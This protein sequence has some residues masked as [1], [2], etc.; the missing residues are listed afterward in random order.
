MKELTDQELEKVIAGCKD[1]NAESYSV[2]LDAYSRRIYAYF[3]RLSGDKTVADD[4]LSEMFVK[5]IEKIDK[6]KAGNFNG[7]LFTVASNVWHDWLRAKQRDSRALESQKNRLEL[8][9][10]RQRE[11]RSNTDSADRLNIELERLDNETREL[12]MMRYY[13]ELSFKE[14]AAVRDVPI[15]TI[16]SKVHRGLKKLREYMEQPSYE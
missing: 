15:G 6:F 3:Y 13:S 10:R 14:I 9:A 5:L 12:M 1:R 4:L 11:I 16:L 7:W 2:L 8:D